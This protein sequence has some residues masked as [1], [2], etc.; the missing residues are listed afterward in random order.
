M[1]F[2]FLFLLNS[3]ILIVQYFNRVA[4]VLFVG[5]LETV[6]VLVFQ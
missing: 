2:E 6:L 4:L 5:L 3:Q 1:E